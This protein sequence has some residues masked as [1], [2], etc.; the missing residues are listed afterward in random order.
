MGQFLSITQKN[1]STK[2]HNYKKVK[3][4]TEQQIQAK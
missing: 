3:F 2:K 1:N 4:F